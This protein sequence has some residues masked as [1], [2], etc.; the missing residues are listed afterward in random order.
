L[1]SSSGDR[2]VREGGGEKEGGL[3]G[4]PGRAGERGGRATPAC[5]RICGAA[6]FKKLSEASPVPIPPESAQPPLDE[7]S[8]PPKPGVYDIYDAAGELQFVGISRSVR[9]SV[10]GHRRKVPA[11]LC[12]SVKVLPIIVP[13]LCPYLA[14][15]MLL[16]YAHD[17]FGLLILV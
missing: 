3:E 12:A 10:E 8:L 11:D 13:S 9:T 7:E 15:S 2:E 4:H 6:T 14:T 16:Q 5:L 1:S 17:W